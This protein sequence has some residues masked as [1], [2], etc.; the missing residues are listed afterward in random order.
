[1]IPTGC[2]EQLSPFGH[3]MLDGMV[4]TIATVSCLA[5]TTW[6]HNQANGGGG[7]VPLPPGHP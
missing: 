1:M 2:H 5:Y 6:W 4:D 3:T 7:A